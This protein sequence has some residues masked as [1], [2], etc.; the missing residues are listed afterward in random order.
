MTVKEL[1]KELSKFPQDK[2]VVVWNETLDNNHWNID[3]SEDEVNNADV[4][5]Y[6]NN[7]T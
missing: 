6:P 7:K 3:I 4:V 5:L 2:R 1:I